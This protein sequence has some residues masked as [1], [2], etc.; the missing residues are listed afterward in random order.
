MMCA[1][2]NQFSGKFLFL[3]LL[4]APVVAVAQK[5]DEEEKVEPPPLEHITLETKDGVQLRCSWYGGMLGKKS[6]PVIMLHGWGGSR[7]QYSAIAK[8]LQ[9]R[10]HAVIVPDLRGFGDSKTTIVAGTPQKFDPKRNPKLTLMGMGEDIR[11]AKKFLMGKNNLGEL[12]IE[13]L[14]VVAAEESCIPAM[15][16]AIHDWSLEQFINV[17]RGRDVKAMILLSPKRSDSG[18]STIRAE[19]HPLF[20]GKRTIFTMQ[21]MVIAGER[22]RKA[23]ADADTIYK[24][25]ARLRPKVPEGTPAPKK[26]LLQIVR[27]TELQ[28]TMLLDPRLSFNLEKQIAGFIH[29]R[30]ELRAG[31]FQWQHRG[32]AVGGP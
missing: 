4:A 23:I 14:C 32:Q 13:M 8:H 27:P 16:W 31:E 20:T 18:L 17:K 25:L 30:L 12:N 11:A 5:K 15:E 2:T 10:G 1:K 21:L 9:N 3:C 26:D 24:S 28:G 7:R 19:K 29:Y 22:D 6:V